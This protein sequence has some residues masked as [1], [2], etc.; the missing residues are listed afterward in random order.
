MRQ[1]VNSVTLK[2]ITIAFFLTICFLH[3][4][5]SNYTSVYPEFT[6]LNLYVIY[7]Y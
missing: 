7:K 3:L 1:E 4:L 2:L 6:M 5:Y